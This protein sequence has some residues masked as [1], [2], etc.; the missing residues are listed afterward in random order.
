MYRLLFLSLFIMLSD[1]FPT[2]AQQKLTPELLWTIG[3]VGLEDVSPDGKYALYGVQR[4][5]VPTNKGSRVLYLL[6]IKT[7]VTRALTDP[8]ETSSDAEFRPDG[9]KIGFLR[10][11]KLHE[12]NVE[13]PSMIAQVSD[14][15]INGFHYSPDGK[16]ILFAQD[17][18]LDQNTVDRYPDLPKA[19]GR[20]SDGLLYRH[21]KSW[22]D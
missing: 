22:H 10:D 13:G 2:N 16:S 11:G 20:I 9:K 5:D 6:E 1:A 8:D 12:V 7:G 17:V 4:Y 18:K 21:W 3:R 15:E 14:L 19:S